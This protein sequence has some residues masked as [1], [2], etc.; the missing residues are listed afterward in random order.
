MG[1]TTGLEYGKN[2]TMLPLQ[3]QTPSFSCTCSFFFFFSNY[4]KLTLIFEILTRKTANF[5]KM[6]GCVT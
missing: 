1:V 3:G 6:L 4:A 2:F 5:P